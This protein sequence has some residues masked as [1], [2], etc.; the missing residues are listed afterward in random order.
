MG[1]CRQKR[2]GITPIRFEGGDAKRPAQHGPRQLYQI[3]TGKWSDSAGTY[4]GTGTVQAVLK[5][6]YR[7]EKDAPFLPRNDFESRGASF[8]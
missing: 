3:P 7:S 4:Q 8:S 5:V 6:R 2:S 1:D